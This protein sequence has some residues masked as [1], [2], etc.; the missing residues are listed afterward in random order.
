MGS[1]ALLVAL[2][3]IAAF[4]LMLVGLQLR[5]RQ[6][7]QTERVPRPNDQSLEE[8]MVPPGSAELVAEG[9]G[10]PGSS[11][12]ADVLVPAHHGRILAANGSPVAAA[13]VSWTALEPADLEWES[14][15]Q[16]D[17]WGA[18]DRDTS[19]TTSDSEGRYSFSDPP[20]DLDS[21]SVIWATHPD[22]EAGCLLLNRGVDPATAPGTIRLRDCD[23][24]LVRVEDARG[25]PVE[26]AEV[27]QYGLTPRFAPSEGDGALNEER[28]RRNLFRAG[29]TGSDGRLRLCA[30][31]GEQVLLASK[32]QLRCV[33]W[34]GVRRDEVVLKLVEGFSVSG[35]VSL[36]DWSHL[37]YAGERRITIS[38]Q[39]GNVWYGLAALRA[40]E[41]GPFGPVALPILSGARY[42]LHLEGSPIIPEMIEFEAPTAGSHLSFHLEPRVGHNV[43]IVALDPEQKPILNSEATAS[44]NEDG[45]TNFVHRRARPDGY[46][47]LWS[48]PE[49][50][51]LYVC[52]SA[53]GYISDG[54]EPLTVPLDYTYEFTLQRAG[55]LRGRCLHGGQPVEDFQIVYWRPSQDY[56]KQARSFHGREDGSFELDDVPIGDVFITAAS[57]AFIAGEARMVSIPDQGAADVTLELLSAQIGSGTVVDAETEAP[58]PTAR[59]QA[60]LMGNW[61]PVAPWGLPVAADGGGTFEVRGLVL[62]TNAIEVSAPGYATKTVTVHVAPG[63]PAEVGRVALERPQTLEIQLT[64]DGLPPR[65][66]DFTAFQ[67][68]E[69]EA[70]G[71]APLPSRRFSAEG[72]ARFEGVGPG[73]RIIRIE[74]PDSTCVDLKLQLRAGEDWTFS[75]RAAGARRLTIKVVADRDD[76]LEQTP[77][78]SV[79]YHNSQDV[80][81]GWV[82]TVPS[83]G[84]VE[85]EGIDAEVVTVD[86]LDRDWKKVATAQGSFEGLDE[87]LLTIHVGEEP[88]VFRVVDRDG[89]PVSGAMVTVNDQLSPSLILQGTTDA[90]GRCEIHGVPDHGIIVHVF[91]PTRGRRDGVLLDGSAG[92]AELVL[93]SDARIVLVLMDGDTP[94]SDVACQLANVHG[95]TLSQPRA[96]NA[97]GILEWTGLTAGTYQLVAHHANC[98]PITLELEANKDPTPQVVQIR[99]LGDL[100]L[101]LKAENGLPISGQAVDLESVEFSASVAT[102]LADERVQAADGLTSDRKGLIHIQGLPRGTYRWSVTAATGE[103]YSGQA[104]VHAGEDSTTSIV[105]PY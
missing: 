12:R 9:R 8:P 48:F 60:S 46:I 53:P 73:N 52:V 37:N 42:R 38:A 13:T 31:P 22:F 3:V 76:Y 84:V 32:G 39:R 89:L 24:L 81:T 64:T 49:G 91:H 62:G 100:T 18:L 21:G 41:D 80:L 85:L 75:H 78:M 93:E 34:R 69:P 56:Y 10:S 1:R 23:P 86:L 4:L 99:R 97:S 50:T 101:E 44:W 57:D 95:Q 25:A 63:E 67:V 61:R 55:H 88:F 92:E 58:I 11:A 30:F 65:S 70:V 29:E 98:W 19:W 27:S 90:D 28:A 72:R 26:A 5:A 7:S 104:E 6:S 66:V 87:L 68:G 54:S 71:T 14:A 77:G 2:G 82:V 79:I 45:R 47:D 94:V 33:P 74:R 59:I 105:L 102:W 15:W 20:G 51:I 43:W 17:E 83:S 35:S 16:E 103:T 36:P 96:T 40:I